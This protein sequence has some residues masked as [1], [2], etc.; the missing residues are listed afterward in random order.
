MFMNL[1]PA[2]ENGQFIPSF[3]LEIKRFEMYGVTDEG[4]LIDILHMDD[5]KERLTVS[6]QKYGG[7]G[8][9][10]IKTGCLFMLTLTDG[11]PPR[12]VVTK[13]EYYT[14]VGKGRAC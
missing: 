13:D 3:A 2:D 12:E 9:G 7:F 4:I 14:R 5:T 8:L 11:W 10:N 6:F 1:L